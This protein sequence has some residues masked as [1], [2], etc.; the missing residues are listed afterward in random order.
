MAQ[1]IESQPLK[2]VIEPSPEIF[3]YLVSLRF[4]GTAM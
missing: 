3:E 1:K 2:S 4:K